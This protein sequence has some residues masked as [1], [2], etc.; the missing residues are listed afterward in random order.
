MKN[1]LTAT[2]FVLMLTLA[3]TASAEVRRFALLIGVNDGGSERGPLRYAE[4][5]AKAVGAVL[6]EMGGV[7]RQDEV[8]V[9]GATVIRVDKALKRVHDAL[10]QAREPGVRTEL[11]IYYSGHSDAHGLLLRDARYL[12]E[13]FRHQIEALPADVRIVVVDSCASGALIRP[14]GGRA[15]PSF[16]ID[17]GNSV[18]GQA[19]VTSSSI[20]EAA[21]ESDDLGS[22]YF[23][24]FLVSGLRGAADRNADSRVTLSEAYEFAFSNTLQVTNSSAAGPQHP[25]YDFQLMGHGEVILTAFTP[26]TSTL[27]L[28]EDL[29]GR[30]FVWTEAERL[31]AEAPKLFGRA[32][33]LGLP[34]G[35]YTV[36]V[37]RDGALRRADVELPRI[38]RRKLDAKDFTQEAL[39]ATR[40]RGPTSDEPP[41]EQVVVG[42]TGVR[43][44]ILPTAAAVAATGLGLMVWGQVES[45]RGDADVG[46]VFELQSQLR[47]D[48]AVDAYADASAHYGRARRL[49]VIGYTGLGLGVGLVLLDTLLPPQR[50]RVEVGMGLGGVVGRVTFH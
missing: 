17:M 13:D 39:V 3:S 15:R 46:R 30:V 43:R 45:D 38:G 10:V 14:K 12:Y 2:L 4:S 7:A 42:H 11:V 9:L 19:I 35:K 33:E 44:L 36:T 26:H 41:I 18:R 48:A 28:G 25:T 47:W 24:H 40:E 37:R 49:R 21:Q 22:S 23:T 34:P 29:V 6:A 8:Y 32:T 5:D 50:R 27:E 20:D 16:L 1:L 31:I